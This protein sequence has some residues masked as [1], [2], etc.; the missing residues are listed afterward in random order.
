MCTNAAGCE[1]ASLNQARKWRLVVEHVA[2]LVESPRDH[3]REIQPLMPEQAR[4]LL[5]VAKGHRLRGLVSVAT[6]L[7]LRMGEALGLQWADIDLEAGTLP[8]RQALERSGGDS[9][10]RCPLILERRD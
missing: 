10:A 6:A 1:S 2:A 8:V 5:A 3:V 9:A 4:T 7:G